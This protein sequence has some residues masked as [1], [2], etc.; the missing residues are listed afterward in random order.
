MGKIE[1]LDEETINK[2]A[3]GEVVERPSS[4][5]KEL[6][7]NAVDAK[8]T[9]VTVEIQE[10]GT[11]LIRITDNGSGMEREDISRAFLRH[12]TS[13]I[14]KAEDLQTI[15]S[16]G[17]RGEALSSISAVAQVELLTK[18]AHAMTGCRYRIDGGIE[19]TME[20]IG[21]PDGTTFIVRQ[22]FYNTP[23]R[24]KFLKTNTTE[25]GYISDLMARLAMSHPE[26]SFKFIN[27]RQNRLHTSGNGRLKDIIYH[28]YGREIS[29]NI[30]PV[31]RSLDG[32]HMTGFIGKPII[33]RGNRS[34]ENYFINGRYVKS[35]VIT[36]AIEDAYKT[37][38]MV[39]KFPFAVLHFTLDTKE[40]DVNVHPTKMEVRFSHGQELYQFVYETIRNILFG[41]DLIPEVKPDTRKETVKLPEKPKQTFPEPFEKRRLEA[42]Q[43]VNPKPIIQN[44]PQIKP[45]IKPQTAEK[46]R[47]I[48]KASVVQTPPVTIKKPIEEP[49]VP[50]KVKETVQQYELF[51]AGLLTKE[52][53]LQHKLIGQIFETYWIVEYDGKLF[54]I[55]Q[56]AAHEK[57]LYEKLMKRFR[58]SQPMIQ[59]LQPPMI[60][61]LSMAEI[62]LLNRYM[63]EFKKMGFEFEAFGGKEYALRGVPSDLYGFSGK[64]MVV[65]LLD[66]LSGEADRIRVDAIGDRI[67]TMAC[68][69]AVKGNMQISVK[70][71][72]AL[73]EELLKA[74]NP[75]TCPHGRPTII[76]MTKTEL[77]KRFK[78]IV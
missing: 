76:A 50:N 32:I 35:P 12:S 7:E 53:R 42:I 75:Y 17:F 10:G 22:L 26:I 58:E 23:A 2:I 70:E 8:A 13:K 24:R 64:E 61:T 25:A 57:V 73:I 29:T 28:I 34:Y 3:A 37:F 67:A 46:P 44:K 49:Q 43:Q 69:A 5:V 20:D 54:I 78:R 36:Q 4:V 66:S 72:D 77:E 62:D 9:A 41:R 21:C 18:T 52:A 39:H 11:A 56:H 63:D 31:D 6:V 33:S 30:L 15:A 45:Q 71:A 14:R 40:L 74:E 60:L 48:E 47:D 19:K 1:V 51:E 27:N 68:K 16:L 55:D 65:E 59:M 38:T